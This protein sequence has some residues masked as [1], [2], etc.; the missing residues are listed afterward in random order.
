M[1]REAPPP[2]GD[3]GGPRGRTLHHLRRNG[4]VAQPL[5]LYWHQCRAGES[6]RYR[7]QEETI[8]VKLE[9][10]GREGHQRIYLITATPPPIRR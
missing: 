6:R 2:P 9:A 7:A 1:E 4:R 10:E 8:E 5:Q 3:G